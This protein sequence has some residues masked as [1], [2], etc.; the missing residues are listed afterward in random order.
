MASQIISRLPVLLVEGMESLIL[1]HYSLT[2]QFLNTIDPDLL[3]EISKRKALNIFTIAAS[4]TPAYAKFL[5]RNR[6][7][8]ERIRTIADFESLVPATDKVNYVKQF[9]FEERCRGGHL[10]TRGNVD[11]SGGTSGIPTNWIHDFSEESLLF[12]AV[13][14]EFNYVFGGQKKDYFVPQTHN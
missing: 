6:V 3:E 11:E 10:P 12:K 2:K 4:E 14:F 5:R 13:N 9:P 8:P 1:S 7:K